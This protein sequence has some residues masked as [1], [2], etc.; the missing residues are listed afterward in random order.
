MC[1]VYMCVIE[2]IMYS[3]CY[4]LYTIQYTIYT[5]HYTVNKDSVYFHKSVHILV[6]C[7]YVCYT[8]TRYSVHCAVCSVQYTLYN[9]QSQSRK[10]KNLVESISHNLLILRIIKL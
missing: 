3:V 6:G 9:V 5:I 10:V 7:M 1:I 4:T 8:Y 2:C